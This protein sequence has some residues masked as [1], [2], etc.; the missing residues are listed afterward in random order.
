MVPTHGEEAFDD[1]IVRPR[2]YSIRNER[3]LRR[4]SVTLDDQSVWNGR[5]PLIIIPQND[6]R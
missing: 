2:C 4:R 6:T 5:L 3:I 1:I